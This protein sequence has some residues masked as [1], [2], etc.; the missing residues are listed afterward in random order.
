MIDG[1]LDAIREDQDARLQDAAARDEV[2][3]RLSARL[4]RPRRSRW[5]WALPAAAA[6]AIGVWALWPR[7]EAID[8]ALV[9]GRESAGGFIDGAR[10]AE[11]SFSDRSRVELEPGSAVRVIALDSDGA[12]LA[13]SRGAL[14]ASVIHREGT[15]W[16]VYAGPF[17]VRVIG[18]SFHV[19]WDEARAAI[20]V[21]VHEG[22]VQVEGACL[23]TPRRVSRGEERVFTCAGWELPPVD[24]LARVERPREIPPRASEPNEEPIEREVPIRAPSERADRERPAPEPPPPEPPPP[25]PFLDPASLLEE[26]ERSVL[27]GDVSGAHERLVDVRRLAPGSDDAALAAFLLGRLAFDQQ[28]DYTEAVR[29][30]STYERERPDGPLIREAMGR[31]FESLARSGD[32]EGARAAAE[33]YLARFPDGPHRERAGEL[34][35]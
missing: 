23:T 20:G 12:T 33:R 31:R 14:D 27:A 16:R 5:W 10:G 29:W 24:E 22:T 26:A 30:F 15:S 3:R 1:I 18:T 13:L 7:E 21:H 28:R 9:R 35:R 32:R 25:V 6:A 2:E 8:Y 17:V 34:L 11:L 4:S 19:Q